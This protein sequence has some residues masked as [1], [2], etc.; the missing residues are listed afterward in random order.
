VIVPD[1]PTS[2]GKMNDSNSMLH[3][4]QVHYVMMSVIIH[5]GNCFPC[6]ALLSVLIESPVGMSG[7]QFLVV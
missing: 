7:R 6:F 1:A 5:V 3:S 4:V 2:P